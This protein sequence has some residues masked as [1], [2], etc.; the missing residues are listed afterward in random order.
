MRRFLILI[1]ILLESNLFG[2]PLASDGHAESTARQELQFFE[3][4]V[5]PLLATHCFECHGSKKQFSEL[6]VDSRDGLLR[7]GENG[8]ALVPGKPEESLLIEAVRRESLEMPPEEELTPEQIGI[9]AEWIRRGAVWPEEIDQEMLDK[10][11][12]IDRHWAFQPIANPPLPEVEQTAWPKNAID[13]YILARL[14]AEGLTPS[15]PADRRTLLRRLAW[16]LTGLPVERDQAEAFLSGGDKQSVANVVDE[17]LASPHY[18]ERWGRYWLD[19]ARYADTK[20]YVFFEKKPF[21]WAHTYRDYV[22]ESFNADKPFDQ[23]VREQLAA[24]LYLE[25]EQ[26]RSSLAALGFV[27]IGARFKNSLPDILDDRIDVVMRGFMGLTVTCAR[28]H[29]HKYDPITSEDYYSLYGIFANS[30]EPIQQPFLHES[31]FSPAEEEIAAKI[32]ELGETFETSRRKRFD[33]M[34]DGARARL[35]ECLRVAQASRAGPE[36]EKFDVIVDGGDLF[37][38]MIQLWQQ[39]LTDTE[40]SGDP[41]FLAWHALAKIPSQQ[42]GEQSGEV[43]RTLAAQQQA[44]SL[45]LSALLDSQ[46]NSFDE[47]VLCYVNLLQAVEAEWPQHQESQNESAQ[48]ADPEKEALRQ[49]LRGRNSPLMTPYAQFVNLHLYPDRESQEELKKLYD[50]LHQAKVGVPVKLAQ[51]LVLYDAPQLADARVFKRGNPARPGQIVPRRFLRHLA[52]VSDETFEAGSGRRQLAEA[53]VSPKNP[54]TA[55]VIANRVWQHHFGSGLVTTPSNF[56]IQGIPPSHP[57][58]LDHLATWLVEHHWSLKALHRYILAS[59]TYQQQSDSRAECE[60]V[61]PDNRLCW[62]MNRRRQDWESLRD[63]LLAT[64]G[65]LDKTIGGPSVKSGMNGDAARRT[66]YSYLDR[67]DFPG[68]FRMFDFPNPDVS[69]GSRNRT[70]VPGQSLFLMNHPLVFACARAV[71]EATS[72]AGTPTG[73]VQALFQTVLQRPPTGEELADSLEYVESTPE[74]AVQDLSWSYGYGVYD[75]TQ[76]QLTSFEEL[77]HWTGEQWQGGA[78][79]PDAKV[80]WVALNANG[81]HPGNDLQHVA[82]A[83]WTASTAATV[84]CHGVF[85]HDRAQG[86]GVAGRIALNG[87]TIAGPWKIH[88]AQV[89][90]QLPGVDCQPGDTIDFIVDI[91]GELGYDS[92]TWAPKIE[93]TSASSGQSTWDYQRDFRGQVAKLLTPWQRLAQVLLLTNE[94]QFID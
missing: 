53:I 9:L 86:N 81:G 59:A 14:E 51:A 4:H 74:V 90:T 6:R 55:R 84:R 42:F 3:H 78:D 94:F 54:L 88:Q 35:A 17:L 87:K 82:V 26:N 67:E 20:G 18:G 31:E 49:V 2:G 28:C 57:E 72:S 52:Y 50:D 7:G 48:R 23:F 40:E 38:R 27:T 79:W 10:Q 89:E 77:P 34:I 69:S 66:L 85:G 15:P 56:G 47:V 12:G 37:P 68:L 29:D 65:Q 5:R 63:A 43:L 32:R 45:V 19:L 39:Y 33:Q 13:Y 71:A 46:L 41:V 64:A 75:E 93:L 21:E 61:D 16:D 76:E 91:N 62:K 8:P 22:I 73:Q 30:L 58:L 24:D 36:T 1:A 60:Q 25:D 70:T 11:R 44:N 83:R 80:G 92:Y